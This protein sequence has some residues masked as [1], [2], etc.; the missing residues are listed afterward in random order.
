MEDALL[1]L[2]QVK[3]EFGD[4][5]HIY[6]E[7]LDIMKTFK[8]QQIDTPG[9]IRR[10]SNLFR[11]NRRLV[12]GF[13]TFLPEGYKIELPEGDGPA[14]AVYRAPGATH[15]IVLG[16]GE[17]PPPP[18]APWPPRQP[19]GMMQG[20]GGPPQ[21]GMPPGGAAAGSRPPPPPPAPQP[22]EG[23]LGPGGILHMHGPPPGSGPPIPQ[24]AR[25]GGIGPPPGSQAGMKPAPPQQPVPGSSAPHMNSMGDAK[26]PPGA[27]P[28]WPPSYQEQQDRMAQQYH[29]QQQQ[30][31]PHMQAPVNG[32]P[33]RGYAEGYASLEQQQQQQGPA[34]LKQPTLP[35]HQQQAMH[36]PQQQQ[37]Q[38]AQH[39]AQQQQ[40]QQQAAGG[41]EGQVVEFD[42]AINYVTTIKKRFSNE[43]TTYKKFLEIL[44]TYQKEQRGIKEV[45]EEVSTLFADHP[46]LLKEFT[47][48]LPDAVQAQ[49]KAQLEIVAKEAEARK[50][51]KARQAI[52]SQAQV[53]QKQ[54]QAAQAHAAA[55]SRGG[56][57]A[58]PMR[59]PP[60]DYDRSVPL[61]FG[62]SQ[63]RTQDQ[64]NAIIRSAHLGIVSFTPVR[65]PR[66]NQ[67][68]PA[69]AAAKRGRPRSIPEL[70]IEPNT[71]EAIFFRRAKD[72][73]LR[74]ELAADK[75]LGFKRHTPYVEF[76][77]CL[78]LYGAGILRKDELFLMLKG[79][80]MQGH[81]PK[82][83]VNV[84]G[85]NAVPA[86]ASTASELLREL[87]ELMIGRGPLAE[88]DTSYKRK[89][90]YGGSNSRDFD[91]TG[92]EAP[93][94]SYRSYPS[95]YP[96]SLFVTNP[97]QTDADHSVLNSK[98]L[99]VGTERR[100]ERPFRLLEAYDGVRIRQNRYEEEMFAIEDDRFEI[101]IAIERN[102][103]TM[104]QIEPFAEEVQKLRE[105]EE[106]DG[107]PIG[108]LQFQLNRY[109]ME[110]IHV[111]AIARI[112]GDK[113][114][115]VLQH[116]LENPLIALPIVYQRLKQ[117]DKEWREVKKELNHRWNAGCEVNYEGSRDVMCP[118]HVRAFESRFATSRLLE[119]CKRARTF[120][121]HP[122]K[123][124]QNPAFDSFSPAYSLSSPDPS[125]LLFQPYAT[126]QCKVDA[127]HKDA[128]R[129][130]AIALKAS[131]ASSLVRERVGRI[132][133]EF[134]VPWFDYPAH[135]VVDE[136]RGTF[137]G[138][139]S[140]N[141]V[142]CTYFHSFSISFALS[143]SP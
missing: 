115:E 41:T 127:S 109:A 123:A 45:L 111:N 93:T 53:T 119:D 26:N 131:G 102:A 7:F 71:A 140:P 135:W 28:G 21:P 91:Y 112:Y 38:H 108:R 16:P 67:L 114:D 61:P 12:L 46:D 106:K 60:P 129:L 128:F 5:P 73:L 20:Q 117:K 17:A 138:T 42:H 31:P 103:Q 64:E 79:L 11:G 74:K 35:P 141:V 68:T 3:C 59:P 25:S 75:P 14:V 105:Q 65:P 139:I 101:D 97:G 47:Y 54:A 29:H 4:Q 30:Q 24:A 8:T 94:P 1:Y 113:G 142:K 40:Q 23:T 136:V 107:Q 62:A 124:P 39:Q 27:R 92:C 137:S 37:Q 13:N 63:G 110:T 72:H 133:A 51:I 122:S 32:G 50:R 77:K 76:L 66:K 36:P 57:P 55:I 33:G 9:V 99:C 2:D 56:P 19:P 81:A 34:G 44:H 69:Q 130:V 83:G 52:M 49:A 80:F 100:N 88:Q 134:M 89:S 104:R 125:S 84:G 70:P 10:V 98:L 132:W 143:V 22:R 6:N 78:H 116:L 48:F 87:E 82:S 58:P 120:C 86:I 96:H 15:G 43:P 95:D 118:V 121:L 126:I 90:K 18:G 85:A